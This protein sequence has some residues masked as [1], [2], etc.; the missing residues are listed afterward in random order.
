MDVEDYL[1]R[2][3][4]ASFRAG[5]ASLLGLALVILVLVYS[6]LK[7]HTLQ[8]EIASATGNLDETQAELKAAKKRLLNTKEE[9]A[10]ANEE[11]QRLE[12]FRQKLL[13]PDQTGASGDKCNP[14]RTENG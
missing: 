10:T 13:S 11:L 14:D 4:K 8:N 7:L 1:A 9:I 12:T 3:G 2:A 5:V 6:S